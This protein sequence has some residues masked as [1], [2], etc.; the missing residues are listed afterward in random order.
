MKAFKL[1]YVKD[2]KLYPPMVS[3]K[4]GKPTPIGVWLKA[5]AIMPC[6][7]EEVDRNCSNVPEHLRRY[8]ILAG[9]KGTSCSKKLLSYRPGWHLCEIPYAL[10][11]NR[12]PFVDNP[13]GL[14]GKNGTTIKVRKYFPANFVWAEVEY[15]GTKDYSKESDERMFY[16]R[17][18]KKMKN[19]N[20]AY[21]GLNHLPDNGFYR[22][23]TNANPAT[24]EWIITDEIKVLRILSKEETDELVIKAGRTPQTIEKQKN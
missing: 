22:Y 18:G 1:F 4:G 6:D 13:M 23:R 3:N 20:H 21:G 8:H 19:P 11:F 15:R 16:N 9:G 14:K 17:N 10:Q 7:K 24:D 5:E 12:G 2:G